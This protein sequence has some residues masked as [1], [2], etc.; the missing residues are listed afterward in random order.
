[1]KENNRLITGMSRCRLSDGRYQLSKNWPIIGRYR[2]SADIRCTS[3]AD[4]DSVCE[5][6]CWKAHHR[7]VVDRDR[8][9]ACAGISSNRQQRNRFTGKFHVPTSSTA[10]PKVS[11]PSRLC[12]LPAAIGDSNIGRCGNV[13]SWIDRLI[14]GWSSTVIVLSTLKIWPHRF[15]DNWSKRNR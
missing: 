9:W 8:L 12:H 7:N 15:W 1:M 10:K 2:L 6:R 5:M 3:R 14:S 13:T 4:G 11:P